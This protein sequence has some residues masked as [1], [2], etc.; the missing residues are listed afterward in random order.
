[1][2]DEPESG[3]R[4]AE[5]LAPGTVTLL[6][7]WL[8]SRSPESPAAD[9]SVGQMV[10]H[11]SGALPA[12]ESRRLVGGLTRSPADRAR[13]RQVRDLLGELQRLSWEA[14]HQRARG[15]GF[16]AEVARE[17]LWLAEESLQA[18]EHA[19]RYWL[20]NGWERVRAQLE[21]GAV[22]ARAAWSALQAIAGQIAGGGPGFALARGGEQGD[23]RIPGELPANLTAS[24]RAAEVTPEGA[25]HVAVELQD[26]AGR[27]SE[28]AAGQPVR[29][30]L[31]ANGLTW[32]LAAGVVEGDRAEWLLPELGSALGLPEGPVPAAHFRIALGEAPA[33]RARWIE[34]PARVVGDTGEETP[35]SEPYAT[36]AT[37]P[38]WSAGRLQLRL[39]LSAAARARY[40]SYRL[41]LLLAV[42]PASE[43]LLGEWPISAWG[44]E[45]RTLELLCPG[46]PAAPVSAD[47]P[48][49]TPLL[50]TRLR[51]GGQ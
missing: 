48:A 17:W 4:S 6:E 15:E 27:P 1:M 24:A 5:D 47:A 43:Q 19:P 16:P 32:P 36:L 37:D 51:P 28:A 39:A 46:I 18:A 23:P 21:A 33:P 38:E 45:P 3:G 40:R 25:L 35:A 34:V 44:D 12:A 10:G 41:E 22:E 7:S 29:L 13:L 31:A 8:I 50:R 11:L 26:A 49:V 9:L 20:A 14:V 2:S 42:T 30:F